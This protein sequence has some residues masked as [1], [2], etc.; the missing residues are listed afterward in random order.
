MPFRIHPLRVGA[1]LL[2]TALVVGG[3]SSCSLLSPFTSCDGTES[4]VRDLA[5]LPLLASA[6]PGAKAAAGD[7]AAY[8]G[9]EDDSGDAWLSAGRL[10][11]YPGTAQEVIAHY[12]KAAAADGW[13]L[14]TPPSPH[15]DP[16]LEACFTQGEEGHFKQ[17]TVN[18]VSPRELKEIYGQSLG[19]DFTTGLAYR[20]EAGSEA[21]GARTP[22]WG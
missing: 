9:C 11:A 19:P 17:V 15:A 18:F 8:S 12:R 16:D 7:A 22:C 20:V 5:A 4:R 21:D 2:S 1:L 3:A 6:P 14:H 13:Q 10:Y